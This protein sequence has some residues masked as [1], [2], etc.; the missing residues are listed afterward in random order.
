MRLEFQLARRWSF[1]KQLSFVGSYHFALT[2]PLSCLI[3]TVK[4]LLN[5]VHDAEPERS[6]KKL[7][8]IFVVDDVGLTTN[9]RSEWVSQISMTPS[10][11][12]AGQVFRIECNRQHLM[13]DI[14]LSS[15]EG[16]GPNPIAS[17]YPCL[18]YHFR[19]DITILDT[20]SE[21]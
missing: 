20:D 21:S 7:C 8:H 4:V 15:S 13:L 17:S 5:D 19:D 2:G 9:T 16:G 11:C 14:R 1:V 3:A 18:R 12:P 6:A 10:K